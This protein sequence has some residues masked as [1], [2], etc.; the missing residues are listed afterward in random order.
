MGP[1]SPA[2]QSVA[3]LLLSASQRAQEQRQGSQTPEPHPHGNHLDA[4]ITKTV[5]FPQKHVLR[6]NLKC[7]ILQL[8]GSAHTFK[9]EPGLHTQEA[10]EEPESHPEDLFLGSPALTPQEHPGFISTAPVHLRAPRT[11][12]L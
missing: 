10:S 12:N 11:T 9:Y 7:L 3:F 5:S 2:A 8:H 4:K 1:S 6:N